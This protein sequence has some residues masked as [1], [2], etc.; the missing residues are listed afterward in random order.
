MNG[1]KDG[2]FSPEQARDDNFYC[3]DVDA[4]ERAVP[5]DPKFM[6]E[7]MEYLHPTE[8]FTEDIDGHL[9]LVLY[10]LGSNLAQMKKLVFVRLK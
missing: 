5:V 3:F 6:V 1:Y 4:D 7:L 9:G 10:T 8:R 2:H